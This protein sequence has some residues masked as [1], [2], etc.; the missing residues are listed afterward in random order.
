MLDAGQL[1][2]RITIERRTAGQDAAGQP[3]TTWE[4][5]AQVWANFRAPS[6]AASAE[7][8]AADR[9]ASLTT[10]SVRI[11]YRTDITAGMRVTEAGAVYD[12]NQVIPD[13]AGRVHTD[14]VC[15]VGGAA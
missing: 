7:R 4:T 9:E 11:R 6:G 5:V 3:L 10:Y 8:L 2:R 12:I 14:L 13:A 1:N 15:T